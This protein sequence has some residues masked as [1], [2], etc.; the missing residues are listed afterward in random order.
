LRNRVG[1]SVLRWGQKT[2]KNA[3]ELS[4]SLSIWYRCDCVR[5][6]W[7]S[8]VAGSSIVAHA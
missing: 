6:D 8:T 5:Q 4:Q 7:D 1:E 3:L 2:M